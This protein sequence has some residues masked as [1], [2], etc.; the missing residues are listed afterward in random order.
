MAKQKK[1]TGV[2]G[3]FD[4]PEKLK[5]AAS[6]VRELKVRQFDA[7][8]PFPVHGLEHAMG[9]PRSKLPWVTFLG[10]ATGFF[11][12]VAL[13]YYVAYLNWTLN[14]GGKPFLSWPAFVPV[15]FEL[16][17]LFAGL[18]TAAAM[19][20]MNGL[21]NFNPQI[22]DPDITNDKFALF[23]SDKDANYN[24]ASFVEI[25]KANGAIEVRIL[26]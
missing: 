17:V 24:E 9:I 20:I 14:I 6:R 5:K 2:V 4:D 3:L 25:M 16:T 21:P 26:K 10:G 8:T 13:Q 18:S 19:L 11:T 1:L 15:M 22:I 12:A 7:F 23:V